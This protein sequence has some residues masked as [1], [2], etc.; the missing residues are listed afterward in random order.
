MSIKRVNTVNG[1]W[2]HGWNIKDT[3]EAFGECKQIG[4]ILILKQLSKNLE[5]IFCTDKKIAKLE[6]II[7]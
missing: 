3:L 4:C 6:W 1:S 7:S 2:I 5:G